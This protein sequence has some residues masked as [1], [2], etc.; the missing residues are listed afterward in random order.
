MKKFITALILAAVFIIA[1]T[2]ANGDNI[3]KMYT[4]EKPNTTGSAP[5][6]TEEYDDEI[7][8]MSMKDGE[9]FKILC[10]TDT[11]IES[12]NSANKLISILENLVK[13]HK[14]DL[15]VF[16]G[17]NLDQWQYAP[18]FGYN[19][20]VNTVGH[21]NYG[22]LALDGSVAA[23]FK[24]LYQLYGTKWCGIMGN[25]DRDPGGSG[26]KSQNDYLVRLAEDGSYGC[27]YTEGIAYNTP[28]DGYYDWK[29]NNDLPFHKYGD[30]IINIKDKGE[31]IY[32][33]AFM[34]SGQ[35]FSPGNDINGYISGEQV[36]WYKANMQQNAVAKYGELDIEKGYF[37]PSLV[38]IH[39][40]IPEFVFAAQLAAANTNG[41]GF[42]KEGYGFGYNGESPTTRIQREDVNYGLFAAV[43]EVG[44]TDIICGHNHDNNSTIYYDGVRLN[45]NNRTGRRGSENWPD[46]RIN[47][48]KM[49]TISPNTYE[50]LVEFAMPGAENSHITTTALTTANIQR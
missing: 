14:P 4:A 27:L 40:P 1:A 42:I 7:Q 34:D 11:H 44:G 43:K 24:E 25:H 37:I 21:V 10:L 8:T 19:A 49:Y 30:Y 39:Q 22:K 18:Y 47:Y 16:T 48:A 15:V 45:Y 2:A 17:D 28:G 38:F 3:V 20:Y 35:H 31:V 46:S 12:Q 50:M 23:K 32:S 36:N 13:A 26:T 6:G 33:L 5:T 41:T 29:P 9:S